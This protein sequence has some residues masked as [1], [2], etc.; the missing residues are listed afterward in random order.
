MAIDLLG[1]ASS[2]LQAFQR[3]IATAG[4]NIDNANTEGYTRQRVDLGTRP[5]SFSGQGFIGNGVQVESVNRLFNQFAIDRLRDTTS[6]STKFDSLSQF[7]A[8][9]SD[10]L[11]NKDAGLNAG[12]E[13]FFNTVQGVANDPASITSRQLMLSNAD[14]LVARFHNLDG[15][16][17]SLR[18]ELN[19]NIDNLVN[20]ING[21]SQAIADANRSIVDATSLGNGQVPNDLVDK[22]DNFINKLS[23]LVTVRTVDQKDGAVNVFVGSGQPLVTR[24]LAAPLTTVPNN[25]DARRTE[26]AII[27]GGARAVISGSLTGGKL[28]AMLEVRDRVLDPAQ[29]ALGRVAITLSETFNQQ[30]KLGMDL[31]GKL[32]SDFFATSAPSV[33]ANALNSGTGAVAASFDAANIDQLTTEDYQLTF[34]T[35]APV[36]TR[37]SDGQV[38]P[39]SGAGTAGNPFQVAGVSLVVSGSPAAGDRFLIRPTRA[40]G[41]SIK[42]LVDDTR[43]IAAAAPLRISEATNINGLPTNTGN[44]TF[45]LKSVDNSFTQLSAG[46]TFTYDAALKQ[47]NYAG[48]ATGTIAYDPATDSGS[49]LT[50]A[51]VSFTVTGTPADTDSFTFSDNANGQSDNSNALLLAGLQ[52][53]KTLEGGS[54]NLQGAYG[55][56]VGKLGS[57][58][59]S[60]QITAGAQSA[61]L[62]QAKASRDAISGVNLDEEAAN[63]LR[64]QQAYQA[65]ARV[66]N[67]ADTIFQT[68]LSAVGR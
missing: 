36:L 42:L 20:D 21:L 63:L 28:G 22:R 15:Q 62:T 46:I 3:S 43:K 39:M 5:P 16:L 53:D 23:E 25:F 68:L 40:S 41:S 12:L 9:I 18:S 17:D 7:S 51:G 13:D 2:G 29:N 45:S 38:V 65:V 52:T 57:Q 50:V 55:Q 61:L 66:I 31:N 34:N 32:G 1:V 58:T 44:G 24:F 6:N 33:A 19:G 37:I 64:F 11:G 67:T 4:H 27:N 49:T 10:L 14:G 60:A 26:V 54:T 8:R 56:L 48:D 35:G 30:H 59:R 47:F